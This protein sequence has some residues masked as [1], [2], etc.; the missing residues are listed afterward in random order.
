M[1]IE[2]LAGMYQ[3]IAGPPGI[4]WDGLTANGHG[5]PD[6]DNYDPEYMQ[7]MLAASSAFAGVI[8][9]LSPEFIEKYRS[10]QGKQARSALWQLQA[11][12]NQAGADV[13][14]AVRDGDWDAAWAF[15]RETALDAVATLAANAS[16][17]AYLHYDGVMAA[18]L[19]AG[20]I[21]PDEL[22]THAQ[23]VTKTFQTFVDMYADGDLDDLKPGAPVSGV[24]EL[25][26]GA[27]IA[28]AVLGV[29]LVLGICYLFHLWFIVA[30]AQDKALAWCDKL[31]QKGGSDEDIRVCVQAAKSMAKNG[32]PNLLEPLSDILKPLAVVAGIG[33]AVYAASIVIPLMRARRAA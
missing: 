25:A 1:F 20:K 16:N 3:E 30:P 22:M 14:H 15:P 6:K 31:V 12:V 32:N 5:I 8:G 7:Y 2:Q 28:I 24:G 13:W 26:T 9:S 17:Q 29:G 23:G 11:L 21:T 19:Y 18:A 27:I 33:L 10:L 4:P